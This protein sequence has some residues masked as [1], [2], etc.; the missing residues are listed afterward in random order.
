[1]HVAAGGGAR[2][3]CSSCGAD[4]DPGWLICEALADGPKWALKPSKLGI[5]GEELLKPN[6]LGIVNIEA[7]RCRACR[8]VSFRY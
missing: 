2:L 7:G 4:M 6:P 5:G 1:V 3:K 8:Q